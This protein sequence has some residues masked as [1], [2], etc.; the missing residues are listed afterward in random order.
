MTTVSILGASGYTGGELLRL[1]LQH[2]GVEVVGATSQQFAGESLHKAHPNLRGRTQLKFVAR[3]EL[4]AADVVFTCVP[5]G[6]GMAAVPA[7]L[8]RGSKVVDLSADFRLRDAATYQEWY[9]VPHAAPDLLGKAVYGLPE[10]HRDAIRGADLVS[11]VGCT[12]TATNLALYPLAK[13]G[14][15]T[16]G[17]VVADIKIGSSA[18]GLEASVASI[19]AERSRTIRLYAPTGHRHVAEV[20][21][22]LRLAGSTAPVHYSAHAVELVRGILAT[23]HVFLSRDDVTDKD[24]WKAYRA[25]YGTEPF[26]RLVKERSGLHRFP[27]P[28][29]VAGSNYADVGFEVEEGTDRAVAVCAI[30]NL[31]KGAAGSAVQCMNLMLGLD[32]TAGLMQIPLHPV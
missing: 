23:C 18:S 27:D 31:V 29:L 12:A 7:L 3:G 11:G 15:L 6:A 8:E 22:V 24:L 4:P 20:D 17:P 14:L 26:V 30:D 16:T 19:H 28:K 2:P 9:G 32:E 10:I 25:A 5:H 21:Q 13:A 1:L